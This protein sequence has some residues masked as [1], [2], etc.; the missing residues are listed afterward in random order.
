MG[1]EPEAA[2]AAAARFTAVTEAF[3]SS[4]TTAR[5]ASTIRRATARAAD[6]AG[7]GRARR[8]RPI[9][10]TFRP[11]ALDFKLA[12]FEKRRV[13]DFDAGGCRATHRVRVRSGELSTRRRWTD[14]S[15]V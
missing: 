13:W 9:A 12:R 5:S 1:E 7:R 6:D 15:R 2:A 11:D 8:R 4:A 3:G 14:L 10:S